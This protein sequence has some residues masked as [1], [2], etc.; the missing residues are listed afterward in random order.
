MVILSTSSC[1]DH[2]RLCVD[3]KVPSQTQ[4]KFELQGSKVMKH[5]TALQQYE[6]GNEERTADFFFF[7]LKIEFKSLL[8][9]MIFFVIIKKQMLF[10]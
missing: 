10:H 2:K 1:T 9:W 3:T 6:V 8:N 7:Y 4:L 5:V